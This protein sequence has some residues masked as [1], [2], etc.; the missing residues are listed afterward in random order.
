MVASMVCEHLRMSDPHSPEERSADPAPSMFRRAADVHEVLPPVREADDV[1]KLHREWIRISMPPA[2]Q[3][4]A[5]WPRLVRRVR[6]IT[7]R[8]PGAVDREM[9]ADLI[10]AIDAVAARCDVIADRL[11]HQNVVVNDAIT[12]FGE[13]LTRLRTESAPGPGDAGRPSPSAAAPGAQ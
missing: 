12:I 13:E 7:R 1:V 9:I 2:G 10:R 3:S 4:S 5:L 6:Q 11:D 8:G